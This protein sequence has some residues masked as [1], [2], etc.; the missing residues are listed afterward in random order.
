MKIKK[1][2]L[3][4]AYN[5]R[6]FTIYK[7]TNNK[8]M[9][10]MGI[11][12]VIIIGIALA[13]DALGASVSIGINSFIK[14]RKKIVYLI[15]FGFFQSSL[16]LLGGMLGNFCNTYVISI[17]KNLGGIIMGIVGALM[18]I[19][20]LKNNKDSI[21]TKNSMVI[22]IGISVS[23]DAMVVGFTAFYAIGSWIVLFLYSILIGL[24]TLLIC[25]LGFYMCKYFRN[26]NFIHKYANLFGGITLI[27]FSIMMI[28]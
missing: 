21:L 14:K 26:I 1:V 22:I 24:I 7:Y 15:S 25:S 20:G 9:C 23:L 11:F 6:S 4:S 8:W 18:I 19:D 12:S 13:M 28:F 2:F 10:F 17:S 16:F 5:L 27:L 3:K